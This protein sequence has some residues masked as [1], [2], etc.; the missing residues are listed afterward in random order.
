[1]RA[2]IYTEI[3][4]Q[5]DRER[6]LKSMRARKLAV[7]KQKAMGLILVAIGVVAPILLDGDATASVE[8]LLPIGL[9]LVLLNTEIR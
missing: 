2:N 9:Y 6:R 7:L 5:L 4:H 3:E 1:M 8:F